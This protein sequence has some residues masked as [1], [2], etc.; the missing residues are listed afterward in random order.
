M[1]TVSATCPLDISGADYRRQLREYLEYEA[2]LQ[3]AENRR[4][5]N[6]KEI[7]TLQHSDLGFLPYAQP[8]G[9]RRVR[10]RIQVPAEDP[11]DV[12]VREDY[13]LFE[14][15]EVLL[16]TGHYDQPHGE[17]EREPVI[18]YRLEGEIGDIGGATVCIDFRDIAQSEEKYK[19]VQAATATADFVHVGELFNRT[20]FEREDEAVRSLNDE[21][22][23]LVCGH[24]DAVFDREA[25]A[26]QESNL[27]DEEL[28]E[29]DRQAEGI[30]HALSAQ[31]IAC[32]QGPPG[33]GKTRVIVELIRRCVD[34]GERVLVTAETHQAVSNIL[35]GDSVEGEP[36]PESLHYHARVNG[37]TV[38]RVNPKPDKI[39]RFEQRHYGK[40]K[41]GGQV[42]ITTNNSAATIATPGS[43]IFDV[44][45]VDEA[46]QARQSSTYIPLSLAERT[47]LVGDHKQL[48]P[49]RPYT[50]D[51]DREPPALDFDAQESAF[52]QLYDDDRGVFGADLG[53]MFDTQYRMHP[54]IVG[55]PS[56][57][58]YNDDLVTGRTIDRF[59]NLQPVLGFTVENRDPS[60]KEVNSSEAE[61][62]AEYVERLVRVSEVPPDEIGIGAA[63][64]AQATKLKSVLQQTGINHQPI[65][66]QTFDSFQG[67]ERS[68]MVLSFTRSNTSGDIGYLCGETGK[69]RL[70]TKGIPII[71]RQDRFSYYPR[72]PVK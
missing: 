5:I 69:R 51:I 40:E 67:S 35:V 47:L 22:V 33:T 59:N 1:T 62:I 43:D 3:R 55:F 34:A 60:E 36:D 65:L 71:H 38:N 54:D 48:G 7:R 9:F 42:Y 57:E 26:L 27:L 8:L 16:Q 49:E 44:A 72:F 52:T 19:R 24:R 37:F 23:A 20:V 28:Y 46:T 64:R 21:T 32:I 31:D 58:F 12:D 61:A 4:D 2:D 63:Y 66:V 45:I 17:E 56:Q 50:P 6:S 15:H 18:D 29:N 68:V 11:D 70:K 30:K 25:S 10:L 39:G 53:V 14:N 13:G 41:N